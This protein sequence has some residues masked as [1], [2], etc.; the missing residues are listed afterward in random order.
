MFHKLW[1]VALVLLFAFSLCG[2]IYYRHHVFPS[3][4][5]L[6]LSHV[7]CGALVFV[8]ISCMICTCVLP[9]VSS[10]NESFESYRENLLNECDWVKYVQ[11][12]TSSDAF[13]IRT[14]SS[15]PTQTT[16]A[17]LM[18][19][20]D[21]K[22]L[23]IPTS[24]RPTQ[25]AY[26]MRVWVTAPDRQTLQHINPF[27]IMYT[28]ASEE[29]KTLIPTQ[30]RIVEEQNVAYEA[31]PGS[32][33]F[34][35]ES[36]E[37]RI[38]TSTTAVYWRLKKTTRDIH[39]CHFEVQHKRG[40]S[41]FEPTDG[42][43]A[44]YSTFLEGSNMNQRQWRD[45]SGYNALTQLESVPETN[46]RGVVL[47]NSWNGPLS[48]V[49]LGQL[50]GSCSRSNNLVDFTVTFYYKPDNSVSESTNVP[51]KIL[52]T[53][54]GDHRNRFQHDNPPN[55]FFRC[56]VDAQNNRLCIMQQNVTEESPD[57][58]EKEIY[59]PLRNQTDEPTLYTIVVHANT[60]T[61]GDVHVYANRQLESY[62]PQ[63]L[64]LDY[65][66]GDNHRI[67]WGNNIPTYAQQNYG[68]NGAIHDKGVLFMHAVYN[69]AL[70]ADQV[71]ILSQYITRK[72]NTNTNN[73]DV[74][75]EY[76]VS[77]DQDSTNVDDDESIGEDN[78]VFEE[79]VNNDENV[80][81]GIV[82]QVACVKYNP[83]D[84]SKMTCSYVDSELAKNQ[85]PKGKRSTDGSF[86]YPHI[87]KQCDDAMQGML[88]TQATAIDMGMDW[89]RDSVPGYTYRSQMSDDAYNQLTP[90]EKMNVL[91]DQSFHR[92]YR[93]LTCE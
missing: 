82:N 92:N 42:L 56:K 64:D 25:L 10:A 20:A 35:V 31:L 63:W 30:Y 59:V 60:R 40:A 77:L 53:V 29:Q 86:L 21:G 76:Y 36:S 87:N 11:Q 49:L 14:Q 26:T 65:E 37:V 93:K 33:W 28:T 90:H 80:K 4:D 75:Y 73:G 57:Y 58:A 67:V 12:N 88:D 46:D 84:L 2:L 62:M 32:R 9:N 83:S 41:D 54:Y 68:T 51:I 15:Q 71:Q 74:Q 27:A 8:L 38:P 52:F 48:S 5:I 61:M 69:S 13:D 78:S 7:V 39:W 44:L 79:D 50:D 19:Y 43:Q 70:N 6:D 55:Y 66:F 18:Q 47:T 45:E 16:Q 89:T 3:L 85:C 72:Y 22:S 81:A 17:V 24:L 91:N 23:D 1:C 34:L